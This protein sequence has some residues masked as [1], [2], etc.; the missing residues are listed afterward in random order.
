MMNSA[1]TESPAKKP[2]VAPALTVHGDLRTLTQAGSIGAGETGN[3][4][5]KGNPSCV[6][7]T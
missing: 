5:G 3:C 6:F 2:Y 1:D 4:Q 7:K